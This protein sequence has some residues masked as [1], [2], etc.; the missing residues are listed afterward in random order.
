MS[1]QNSK[2]KPRLQRPRL[3]DASKPSHDADKPRRTERRPHRTAN[4]SLLAAAR[5]AAGEVVG[6]DGF[7]RATPSEPSQLARE[8]LRM[9]R[10]FVREL[11]TGSPTARAHA[12]AFAMQH[13]AGQRLT[14]AA[15]A[16]G[17]DTPRGLALLERASQCQARS[18]RAATAAIALAGLLDGRRTPKG[19]LA[20]WLEPDDDSETDGGP[21]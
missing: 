11:G 15:D 14:L 4:R 8:A 18:E 9:F 19:A 3:R 7:D 17:L 6:S 20:P 13:A 16:A 10:A 1:I 12:L 5:H 2:G 21:A